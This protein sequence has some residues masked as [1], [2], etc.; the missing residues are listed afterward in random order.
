LRK[1]LLEKHEVTLTNTLEI[2]RAKEAAERQSSNMA[3]SNHSEV[4]AVC[5]KTEPHGKQHT[6]Q[7]ARKGKCFRCGREGHYAKDKECPARNETCQKCKKVGHFQSQCKT[8]FSV[9]G[10]SSQMHSKSHDVNAV[11]ID[12]DENEYAFVIDDQSECNCCIDVC[13]RGVMLP[14]VLID[15]GATCNHMDKATWQSLKQQHIKCRSEQLTK[16]IYAYGSQTA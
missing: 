8:K 13:V 5:R 15:S 2:G 4:N 10:N 16:N 11:E 12:D 14:N 7:M 1:H 9:S 6:K 3:L